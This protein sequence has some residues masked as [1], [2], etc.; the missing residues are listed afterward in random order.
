M[1]ELGFTV[2]IIEHGEP[3]KCY[4]IQLCEYAPYWQMI[5]TEQSSKGMDIYH[6]SFDLEIEYQISEEW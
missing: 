6:I 5:I 3:N 1:K 4:E 2:F